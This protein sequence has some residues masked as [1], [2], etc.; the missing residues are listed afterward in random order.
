MPIIIII[1]LLGGVFGGGGGEEIDR[2]TDH[3]LLL[4]KWFNASE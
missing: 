2:Q 3:Q 1:R 4:E